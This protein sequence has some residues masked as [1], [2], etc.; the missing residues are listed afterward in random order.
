MSAPFSNTRREFLG[1]AAALT[2]ASALQAARPASPRVIGANDR[3]NVGMIGVGT[4]GFGHVRTLKKLTDTNAQLQIVAISDIYQLRRDRARDYL[5]L[6]EKDLTLEYHDLLARPDVDAVFIATPDHWHYRMATDALIAG[7]DVYLEKPMTYKIEEAKILADHVKK[8]GRV[9]QIGSQYASEPIYHKARELMK[10]NIIGQPLLVQ[11]TYSR[12][13]KYGEWDYHVDPEGTPETIDWKRFLGSAPSRPFNA[14]RFFRWRKYWDYSGGISTDLLYHRLTPFLYVLGP[15]FP[16]RVSA[17]GGIYVHKDREVPDTFST[18]IEYQDFQV[19]MTSS[20]ASHAPNRLIPPAIMGHQATMEFRSSKEL[21][22]VPDEVFATDFKAKHGVE[23]LHIPIA[24]TDFPTA[25]I[26]NFFD[27]IRTRQQ[28][29]LDAE[30]GYKIMVAIGLGVE[31]YRE[32]RQMTWDA[33]A[34]KP[35]KT[36]PKRDSYEGDGKNTEE[37]VTP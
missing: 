6:S 1:A 2:G 13:S 23:S 22:I 15:Q 20:M 4:R 5:K 9:M 25:H 7:K 26:Q 34:E 3:I 31:A 16:T 27:C 14:D 12:S 29:V 19:I 33:K 21:V 18:C 32:G 8:S 28:P 35:A 10:D 17:N 11:G 30:Y 24:A 37:S 36:P